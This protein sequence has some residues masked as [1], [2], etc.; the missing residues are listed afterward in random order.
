MTRHQ[1]APDFRSNHPL[2]STKRHVAAAA[3]LLCLTLHAAHAAPLQIDLPAQPLERSLAQLARQAGLQLLMPPELVRNRQATALKGSHELAKALDDLLRGS[4]LR[5]R[6]E[7][8]TLLVEVRPDI[9]PLVSGGGETVLPVVRVTSRQPVETA[10]G[11]VQGYVA[12][13]SATGTKTDTPII[14]TPQ[15]LSVVTADRVAAI[16][17]VTMREALGYTPGVNIEPFGPDSRFESLWINLRGLD[18]YQPGPNLDGLPLR[19]NWTWGAWRV[20]NYGSERTE[21]LRGPA[22]VLYGQA[23]PGGTVNVVSKRPTAEQLREL[24]VQLG[25][26]Q[27]RQV[28]GDLSGPLDEQGQWLYRITGSLRD[29]QY[30]VED[31][32]NKH[33]FIAPSL[34]WRPDAS[35]SLTLLTHWLRD[36]GGTYSR[37]A[38]EEGTLIPTAAG[39]HVPTPFLGDPGFDHMEHD[40][41]AIGYVLEH[42]LSSNLVFRQNLR[43][44][45]VR[46]RLDQ[47]F[48]PAGYITANPDDPA[49]PANF[50]LV[51]RYSFGSNEDVRSLAL[52]NQFETRWRADSWEHTLLLGL[53]HQSSR[54]D[55]VSYFA[56]AAAPLDLYAPVYGQTIAKDDPYFDG[57][58]RLRQTG[59]Y[60]Q[61]Q[62]KFDQRFA[63][64]L[65]GRFDRA[66]IASDDKAGG[67]ANRQTDSKLTGRAGAVWLAPQG[68]APY[69][70]YATSFFPV[71][72]INPDTGKSFEPETGQQW[73][74]GLRWQPAGTAHSVSMAAFD[75]RRQNYITNDD[76][77]LPRQFGEVRVKGLELEAML[78]PM[79]GMNLTAAYTYTPFSKAA[80]Q[81]VV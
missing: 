47:V 57:W 58:T 59:L 10:T 31:I 7:T 28:S 38:M 54:F 6:V 42:R 45:K 70:S 48:S 66:R 65:G 15:S 23:S 36:R 74:L 5:A 76:K 30:P 34:T 77:G 33:E 62:G 32:K 29:A 4:G 43:Y 71:T 68:W 55:Q 53:D 25:S 2:R 63:F 67:V 51:D 14:E 8:G 64:T 40:Q 75:L 16:G 81:E 80:S 13:R 78:Q 37:Y 35:T 1:P 79:S 3:L 18:A 24:Q 27:R 21:V 60:T 39:T 46:A 69:L 22:S 26:N 11:P 12:K 20:D 44:G 41:W 52:D 19:N 61:W 9:A 50:R 17:A 73:E 56:D 49:D 72:T